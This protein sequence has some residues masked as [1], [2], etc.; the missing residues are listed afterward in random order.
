VAKQTVTTVYEWCDIHLID[1]D[2]NVEASF[3]DLFTVGKLTR[4][5]ALCPDCQDMQ[6]NLTELHQILQKYGTK[7]DTELARGPLRPAARAQAAATGEMHFCPVESC[8]RHTRPYASKTG[9]RDHVRDTHNTTLSVLEGKT[10]D[11]RFPC[12]EPGCD[13]VGD[14][15]PKSPQGLGAHRRSVHGVVGSSPTAVA[16]R[17]KAS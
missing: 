5:L 16:N 8:E 15:A 2:K 13:A 1:K 4:N 11:A 17:A 9:L 3:T 10:G 6:V 12:P 14:K 7:P